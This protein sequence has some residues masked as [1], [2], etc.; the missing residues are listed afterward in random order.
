MDT[1]ND[2]DP[3]STVKFLLKS[4]ESQEEYQL[5]CYRPPTFPP[6]TPKQQENWDKAQQLIDDS[7]ARKLK[8]E[9]PLEIILPRPFKESRTCQVAPT[10]DALISPGIR[11]DP[12]L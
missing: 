8:E 3:E 2:Q 7:N 6:L 4:L 9:P 11:R 10:A 5:M 1:T 12:F